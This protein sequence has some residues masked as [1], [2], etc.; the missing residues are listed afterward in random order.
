M[1]R[2]T[3]EEKGGIITERDSRLATVRL[4][5]PAGVL[6]S[7]QMRGIADISERYH[8][9]I[10]LTVRQ[11]I[12]LYH[13]DPNCLSELI[14]DLEKNGTPLGSEKTEVVNITGCPGTD[15][16]IYAQ[17]DSVHLART[18]SER[19][20]GRDMPIKTRIAVSSCPYSCMSER[21]NE[22]GITGVVRPYRRPGDCT[23]CD[24]CTQYCKEDAITVK[25]GNLHM[26]MDL[27]ILCGMCILSCPHGIIHADPPA[28]QITVGGKRGKTPSPG[29]HLVTV[30]SADSAI[31]VVG[32]VV[33]W[34]YRR[35]YEGS[36]LADQLDD[37]GFDQFRGKVMADLP[38]E[39]IETGY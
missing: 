14:G 37:L 7:E 27:C 29:R 30:K 18:L 28:Y 19:H 16:C 24:S 2:S 5:I 6:S 8:A 25:N 4:K 34:I 13:V 23:G 3:L 9:G 32:M 11:T 35:S 12:E 15:R 26:D 38:P 39:E 20:T 33:E 10:A 22:I 31:H 1:R 36:S 21:F 17:I